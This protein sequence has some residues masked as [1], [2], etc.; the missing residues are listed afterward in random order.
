MKV[1]ITGGAGF[2]GQRLVRA[3]LARGTLCDAQG[4]SQPIEEITLLDLVPSPLPARA[5]SAVVCHSVVGD[6]A[7]PGLLNDLVDDRTGSVFHLSAV[8]SGT[9]EADFGLGWRVNLDGTRALL[10]ACRAR[11]T[12]PRVVF[13]SSVA[14]YGAVPATG[15]DDDT[16]LVPR[17]SYGTQKAIAELLLQDYRRKGFVDGRVLRLPTISVRPGRPNGA[18]S[19]FA[20]AIIRE[21][22]AGLPAVCP[23]DPSTPI[24]LLSPQRAVTALVLGHELAAEELG[25]SPV[26]NL[27]GLSLPV[28]AMVAALEQ[29][30]GAEVAGLVR[31]ERDAAIERIVA[32][33]PARWD[34]RRA[35]ALGFVGDD[36]FGAV[37]RSYQAEM[38]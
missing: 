24:W 22:L 17:S 25:A 37:I 23:V 16:A 5:Q 4:R 32:S 29:V 12:R 10:E 21:P 38:P 27:P 15:V 31:W 33:W 7:E 3:L 26:V 20:S 18:A 28:R 2:L 30:A 6:I 19:S 8:V 9:A 13:T 1:L 34:T 35:H 36:D 11:A 14:V